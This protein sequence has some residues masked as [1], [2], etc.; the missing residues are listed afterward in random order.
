MLFVFPRFRPSAS[1][2]FALLLLLLS[3]CGTVP[4]PDPSSQGS[5]PDPEPPPP[6]SIEYFYAEP[7]ALTDVGYTLDI[8]SDVS[9]ETR[10]GTFSLSRFNGYYIV[11]DRNPFEDPPLGSIGRIDQSGP[12][13][14]RRTVLYACSGGGD[15]FGVSAPIMILQAFRNEDLEKPGALICFW[16][17]YARGNRNLLHPYGRIPAHVEDYKIYQDEEITVYD[18]YLLAELPLLEDY[19]AEQ[20]EDLRRFGHYDKW[21]CMWLLD[22]DIWFRNVPLGG[23]GRFIKPME[24]K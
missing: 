2:I 20:A 21:P 15:M 3:A 6:E 18:F 7:H 23:P 8:P 9:L 19:L 22:V 12:I 11:E 24:D 17:P 10:E 1:L 13:E 5:L 14:G 4:L 16:Q